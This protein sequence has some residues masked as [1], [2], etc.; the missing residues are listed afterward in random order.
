MDNFKEILD[1][2]DIDLKDFL[3]LDLHFRDFYK[4][5]KCTIRIKLEK[6]TSK[7]NN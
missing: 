3:T 5:R 4:S 2:I 7:I 6:R 1:S